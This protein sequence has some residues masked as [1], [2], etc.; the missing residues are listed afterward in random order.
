MFKF[1]LHLAKF[2]PVI[3]TLSSISF[4]IIFFNIKAIIFTFLFLICNAINFLFKNLFFKQLYYYME[5][6]SLPI[7]G[8][9]DR[10]HDHPRLDKLENYYTEAFSFGMPSG[11]AQ[12]IVFFST[13]WIIYILCEYRDKKTN[14]D[15]ILKCCSIIYM[16]CVCILVM[17]NRYYF[18]YHTFE[19]ITIG[20]II[21]VGLGI[22]F[23]YLCQNIFLTKGNTTIKKKIID[24]RKKKEN[25]EDKEYETNTRTLN[26]KNTFNNN[27]ILNNYNLNENF[28]SKEQHK[29]QLERNMQ[30]MSYDFHT[31]Q[32]ND[33]INNYDDVG[34][35]N[36]PEFTRI[37][38]VNFNDQLSEN[39]NQRFTDNIAFN[40]GF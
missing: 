10:P 15:I 32:V 39:D 7:L 29:D 3:I 21:G 16:I 22:L 6:R 33:Y 30:R 9:G 27:K 19:Q 28:N 18:K 26:N 34:H 13:F 25:Y 23:F 31:K 20:A 14:I 35:Y 5:K 4:G 38:K 11:H 40:G 1:L 24:K 12:S 2:I 8:I 37:N 36:V 17:F